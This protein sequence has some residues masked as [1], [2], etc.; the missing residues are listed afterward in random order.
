MDEAHVKTWSIDAGGVGGGGGGGKGAECT[1]TGSLGEGRTPA[2]GAWDP[3]N[4]EAFAVAE[5]NALVVWDVRSMHAAQTVA[6]AHALQVRDVDY[7][8]KRPHVLATA[9]DDG[10]AASIHTRG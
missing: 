2:G 7:N 3:N 1:G 9:G 10:R 6:G 5:G 8:P 4:P